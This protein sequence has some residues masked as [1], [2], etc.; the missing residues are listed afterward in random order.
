MHVKCVW[1]AFVVSFQLIHSIHHGVLGKKQTR[2]VLPVNRL[3][4]TSTINNCHGT[5]TSVG[6][7]AKWQTSHHSTNVVACT[8]CSRFTM[9]RS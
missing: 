8:L 2:N 9:V 5:T 3:A 6:W 4:L 7:I 1:Y